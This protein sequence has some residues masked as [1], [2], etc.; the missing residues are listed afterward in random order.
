ME[1]WFTILDAKVDDKGDSL[2][3]DTVITTLR[4][5]LVRSILFFALDCY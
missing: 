5:T 2:D 4:L 3:E 1:E